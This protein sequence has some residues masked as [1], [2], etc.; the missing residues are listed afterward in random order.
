MRILKCY[1]LSKTW[2]VQMRKYP[3]V[4]VVFFLGW[5]SGAPKVRDEARDFGTSGRR[6]EETKDFGTLAAVVCL[7]SLRAARNFS[8]LCFI[9]CVSSFI[10]S[11]LLDD[12]PTAGS[13]RSLSD[14]SFSLFFFCFF[15]FSV[16]LDDPPTAGSS[17]FIIS[18]MQQTTKI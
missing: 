10:F 5:D 6:L 9:F 18:L 13:R 12:P 11:A 3:G 7:L 16:L 1:L 15:V 14:K 8:T 4:G 2:A 17:F